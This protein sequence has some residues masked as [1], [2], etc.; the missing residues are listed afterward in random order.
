MLQQILAFILSFFVGIAPLPD[1]DP[2][3]WPS[4]LS[5]TISSSEPA[6]PVQLYL[7]G[8]TSSG[9][10]QPTDS[11]P[12]LYEPRDPVAPTKEERRLWDHVEVVDAHTVAI[13][14]M[15]G[16]PECFGYRTEVTETDDTV[17]I[18]LFSATDFKPGIES[19]DTLG[20]IYQM[21]VTTEDPI[22]FKTIT[23]D[24]A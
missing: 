10:S 11:G 24:P 9:S 8:N 23:Q 20:L 18:N 7:L 22:L 19:C 5:S 17:T 1:T 2:A 16:V 21:N 12:K 4:S 6:I 15:G 3:P 14:F 13:Y